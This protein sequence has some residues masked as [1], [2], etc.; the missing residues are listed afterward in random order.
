VVKLHRPTRL[1][2]S[3]FVRCSAGVAMALPAYGAQGGRRRLRPRE[4]ARGPKQ[5]EAD[6]VR[7]LVERRSSIA[8]AWSASRRS[9]AGASR[10]SIDLVAGSVNGRWRWKIAKYGQHSSSISPC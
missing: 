3:I 8:K 4:D 6:C 2:R 10:G 5:Q 7:E 1:T 9:W